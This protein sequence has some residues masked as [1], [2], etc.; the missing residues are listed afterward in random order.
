M[1]MDRFDLSGRTALITGSSKGIGFALA[2]GLAEAGAALV[3]NGRNAD[4]LETART[5]LSGE[6]HT[7]HGSVFDVTDSESIGPAVA[8]I[9]QDIG[10]IDILINNAG[11]QFRTPLEDYPVEIWHTLMATNLN[12]PCFSSVRR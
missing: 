7:V 10:S 11:M 5:E 9:E 12:S 3:L 1:T 4:R 8:A 2:R 6:G